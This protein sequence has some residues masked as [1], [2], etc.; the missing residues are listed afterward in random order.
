MDRSK[1]PQPLFTFDDVTRK[2]QGRQLTVRND[3][4]LGV[5]QLGKAVLPLL[6]KAFLR[7]TRHMKGKAQERQVFSPMDAGA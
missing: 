3:P 4:M 2:A 5:N 1:S 7:F 6:S